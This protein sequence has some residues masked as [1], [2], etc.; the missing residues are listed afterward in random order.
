MLQNDMF[1]LSLTN[2]TMCDNLK[3]NIPYLA[4]LMTLQ[5]FDKT[6]DLRV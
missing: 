4:R 5:M 2:N 3:S 1:P 6:S